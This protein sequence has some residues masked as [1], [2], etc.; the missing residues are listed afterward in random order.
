MEERDNLKNSKG[1]TNNNDNRS[2]ASSNNDM[3]N[4]NV[5]AT[6]KNSNIKATNKNSNTKAN[7]KNSNIK[8]NNKNSKIKANNNKINTNKDNN[9]NIKNNAAQNAPKGSGPAKPEQNSDSN[10]DEGMLKKF[11]KAADKIVGENLKQAAAGLSPG[12]YASTGMSLMEDMNTIR[13]SAKDIA[14]LAMDKLTD[15]KTNLKDNQQSEAYDK[16]QS[17][18]LEKHKNQP[19]RPEND[20]S[21]TMSMK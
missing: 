4:N 12:S 1:E 6:N 16:K 19:D 9:S 7:N 11:D 3:K 5:K 20:Q 14:G 10:K 18:S 21:R 15:S 17:E 8:A 13:Q 2:A